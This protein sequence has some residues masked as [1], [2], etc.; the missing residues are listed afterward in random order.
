MPHSLDSGSVAKDGVGEAVWCALKL[1]LVSKV[2]TN[3]SKFGPRVGNFW[4]ECPH[5][6]YFGAWIDFGA[7]I[8]SGAWQGLKTWWHKTDS[9]YRDARQIQSKFGSG[10][11]L[12]FWMFR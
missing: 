2:N 10:V 8:D 12:Y 7:I 1:S 11:A 5:I 4:R 9:L 3:P 6:I